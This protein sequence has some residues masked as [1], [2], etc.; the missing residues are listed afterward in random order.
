MIVLSA[1]HDTPKAT[2]QR[3]NPS[4]GAHPP[5]GRGIRP[6]YNQARGHDLHGPRHPEAD[7]DCSFTIGGLT[8]AL[9]LAGSGATKA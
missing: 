7:P 1:D 6:I 3:P 9:V 2:L 5:A 8:G 4:L